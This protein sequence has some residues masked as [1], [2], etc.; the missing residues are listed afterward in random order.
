MLYMLVNRTRKG[1][2]EADYAELAKL[3]QAFYDDLP[4]GLTLHDDWAA[5]DQSCTFAL[6][7]TDDPSLLERVQAPFRRFV[8]MEVVAVRPIGG[9]GKD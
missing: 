8:D 3:A 5:M 7:E 2:G 4:D 9:W 1:L 6:L